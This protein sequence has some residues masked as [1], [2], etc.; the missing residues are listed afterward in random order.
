LAGVR[1]VHIGA[2]PLKV[3]ARQ[4]MTANRPTDHPVCVGFPTNRD[5]FVTLQN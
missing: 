1:E 3:K 5:K 4:E 2:Q